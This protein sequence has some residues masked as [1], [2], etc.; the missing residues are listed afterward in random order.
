LRFDLPLSMQ[1]GS[2]VVIGEAV[3]LLPR[4]ISS[5]TFSNTA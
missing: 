4:P 1:I 5:Q 2:D 3:S